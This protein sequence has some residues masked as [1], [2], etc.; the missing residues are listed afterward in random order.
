V[1]LA[2][3]KAAVAGLPALVYA[4]A[5]DGVDPATNEW[6]VSLSYKV[7]EGPAHNF[8]GRQEAVIGA[9]DDRAGHR[10][11]VEDK[12]SAY[13][14]LGEWIKSDDTVWTSPASPAGPRGGRRGCRTATG[15]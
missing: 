11:P 4:P 1:E 7:K 10:K 13:R 6:L 15:R 12:R 5:F 2:K 9:I 3:A 14:L 8:C